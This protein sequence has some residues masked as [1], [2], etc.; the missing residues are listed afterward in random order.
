MYSAEKEIRNQF[1]ALDRTFCHII[2]RRSELYRFLEGIERICV[3]GCGSSYSTA[4]SSALHFSQQTGIAA[5]AVA[6]GDL[7]V[8]FDDYTRL[9]KNSSLLLLSR[10]GST[11]ELLLAVQKC[12]ELYPDIRIISICAVENAPVSLLADLGIEIPWAFDHSICQT[13][14]VSNLYIG[15]LLLSAIKGGNEKLIRDLSSLKLQSERFVGSVETILDDLAKREW[16]HATILA[17]SGMAGIAE[18]GALAFKEMCLTRSNFYN[19]LDVRHGPIVTIGSDSLVAI[20]LSQG[21]EQLQIEL[22]RDIS[23]RTPDVL[24]FSS[25]VIDPSISGVTTIVL[26]AGRDDNANAIFMLYCVQLLCLK[27]ALFLGLD[28]DSPEGLDAWIRLEN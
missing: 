7:L 14:T 19:V 27:R 17:D 2:G 12:R 16:R 11:S 25:R 6:A 26:P 28:P 3:L 21:D 10:S 1:D 4:K 15:A 22:A 23:R 5:W 18:E 20:Y 8:N 24:V 13:R 9:L